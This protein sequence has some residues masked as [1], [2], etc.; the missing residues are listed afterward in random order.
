MMMK[1]IR[2]FE[3]KKC[4]NSFIISIDSALFLSFGNE[5]SERVIFPSQD[6]SPLLQEAK[7]TSMNGDQD[8]KQDNITNNDKQSDQRKFRS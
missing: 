3:V 1:I 2:M 6:L 7:K 5:I 8:D 4:S